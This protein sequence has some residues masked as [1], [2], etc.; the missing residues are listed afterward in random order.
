M[1]NQNLEQSFNNGFYWSLFGL[2]ENHIKRI[3]R[4]GNKIVV[5]AR[6]TYSEHNICLELSD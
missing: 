1:G 3:N 6:D 5:D 2:I 4:P